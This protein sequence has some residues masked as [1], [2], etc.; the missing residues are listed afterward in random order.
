MGEAMQ[1]VCV[2]LVG[3][4]MWGRNHVRVYSQSND[5]E[6][7]YI[8]DVD[9]AALR[10]QLASY[11]RLRGAASYEQILDDAQVR[12]LVISTPA[13]THYE[14][15]RSAIEAGKDVFIEKPMTMK[16]EEGEELCRLA[17]ERGRLIQVGHLLLYHPAV[18]YLK[19]QIDAGALGEVYY[20]Y[21]QR[22]N[23]G[24]VRSEENALWS[25]APH[26]VSLANYLLNATP[27]QLK[28]AGG[29]YL[30]EGI[31]DVVFLNLTY[32]EGKIA[33]IH[34]AWLDPH[35]IRRLTIV[36]SQKMAVF[37]DTSAGE[38][39][40]IYDKGVSRVEYGDF[41]EVLAVRTGD[42]FIPSIPSTEPLKLQALQFLESVRT[43]RTP[44][45][46][47][48]QGLAVVRVLVEASGELARSSMPKVSS[49]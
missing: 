36:G 11:P 22:V 45:A 46:D 38:K 24:V 25:L 44:L 8:Y 47:G 21:A 23:L 4:G 41:G 19:Q 9:A 40:R 27:T 5:C 7:K 18:R 17:E 29:C 16:V 42:V 26:D 12:A 15:A 48:L 20:L 43:R 1:P 14:L 6:V 30:Q 2:A 32:P 28:A 37:D 3:L 39:V 34:A 13:R 33:S 35:K 31:E 49:R 10:D